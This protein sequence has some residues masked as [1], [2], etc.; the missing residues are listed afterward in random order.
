MSLNLFLAP[1][2]Q[3]QTSTETSPIITTY[4][5]DDVLKSLTKLSSLAHPNG[6][7]MFSQ[8]TLRKLHMSSH[9][10]CGLRE[11]L[12]LQNTHITAQHFS[13][14]D[15]ASLFFQHKL[16]FDGKTFLFLLRV[17]TN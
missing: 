10:L 12:S 8:A 4:N 13:L 2:R 7:S 5:P 1:S 9:L 6:F 11:A 14:S 16:Y 17:S 15:P 3:L